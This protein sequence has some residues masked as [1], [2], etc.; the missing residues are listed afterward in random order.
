MVWLIISLSLVWLSLK[1]SFKAL[2]FLTIRAYTLLFIIAV[3]SYVSLMGQDSIASPTSNS[4]NCVVNYSIAALDLSQNIEI[5]SYRV[6]SSKNLLTLENRVNEGICY[7]DKFLIETKNKFLYNTKLS[8]KLHITLLDY[9]TFAVE[10]G[11]DT[12]A[13]YKESS[14]I[15]NIIVTDRV[16]SSTDLEH[17]LAHYLNNYFQDFADKDLDENLAY[18]FELFIGNQNL[19]TACRET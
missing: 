8:K 13:K 9:N 3:L 19:I 10:N 14:N 4:S 7:Y 5:C 16:F 17:E 1:L 2:R 15:G 18:E 6:L 12:V 11:K